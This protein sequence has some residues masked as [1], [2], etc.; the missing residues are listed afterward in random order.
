MKS[1]HII[2]IVVVLA[3]GIGAYLMFFRKKVAVGPAAPPKYTTKQGA[4]QTLTGA[5][6]QA[7][8]DV[9]SAG[10]QAGVNAATNWLKDVSW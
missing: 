3:L 1:T 10:I 5:V 2:I 4:Q 9:A 7:A 8:K 6:N